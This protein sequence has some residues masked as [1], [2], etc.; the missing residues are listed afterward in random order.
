MFGV[1]MANQLVADLLI[2][3]LEKMG[4]QR[5]YGVVGD[6][7]NAMTNSLSKRKKIEWIHTRHEEAAAFAAGAEAQITGQLAVCAGSCGPGNLHLI[8]GL[9]DAH[10]SGAPVLAIAAQ[11]P[12]TEIGNKYFQ[13]TDP[14]A[15][16][17]DCSY[18]CENVSYPETL[19]TLLHTAI[20]TALTK[21]GVSVLVLS[22]DIALKEVET[23]I[24]AISNIPQPII[25]PNHEELKK[26][27]D[28]LN[29][30]E[31]IAL[32]CGAGVKGAH[33]TVIRLA[34]TLKSP[35]VHTLRGKE[36]IE[37]DNPFDVGMTGLI[38]FSSG[39]YTMEDCDTL[40]LLGTNF[41]YRAFYPEKAKVIQIDINGENL[42]LKTRID[43]GLVGDVKASVEALLPLLNKKNDITF[44]EKALKHYKNAR[45]GLDELAVGEPGKKP[46]YPQ[47]FAKILSEVASEDTI[48]TCDVGTQTAWAAR[49]LKMNGKRRLLGSFNHGS[50][51]NAL[52][53][54][55]GAQ[56]VDKNRQVVAM[57]GDGGFAMLMGEILTLVQEQ[58]PLK[59]IVLNNSTLGFVQLEMMA[60]AMVPYGVDLKNPNF[61]KLGEAVGIKGI[62]IEDPADLKKGLE[63]AFSHN[64]PVIVDIVSNTYELIM[65]PSIKAS[66]AKDFGLFALK[67]VM[68]SRGDML[69][70][71]I[72]T[73]L[74]K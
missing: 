27:A 69:M 57:C 23:A 21:K 4:V 59:A 32:F 31:K 49:Y 58:I 72:K 43:L 10:R 6:S 42:G 29:G 46:I 63:E 35:I 53:Q 5:I 19:P 17:K 64:G 73:N 25:I 55:I 41:P 52:S 8:N 33:D 14:K 44:L 68:S 62:R 60:S 40:L 11:I 12:S 2:E 47:Y 15:L 3:T 13:E 65:P 48:F 71:V 70:D 50:M 22:G 18:F 30:S 9:Y 26:A 66:Q 51:A 56:C 39:Y 74:W 28:I 1:S 20:Q 61:A 38:G 37:Y 16:F 36:F 54:A 45:K 67:A 24:R 34:D 7:L